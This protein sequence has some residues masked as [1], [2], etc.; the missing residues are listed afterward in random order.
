MARF[1]FKIVTLF[2]ILILTS[3]SQKP[4]AGG[5]CIVP[6]HVRSGDVIL[7]REGG[8]TSQIFATIA[9]E[10]KIFSHVGIIYIDHGDTTVLH[11]EAIETGETNSLRNESFCM[12]LNEA[13]TFSIYQLN[14]SDSLSSK[15]AEQAHAMYIAGAK[16]DYSFDAGTDS[17]LYCTEYVAKAINRATSDSTITPNLTIHGKKGFSIDDIAAFCKAQQ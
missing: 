8:M 17:L 14:V 5:D 3:C 9:S 10:E 16:F 1:I 12:F 4:D 15:V 11:C 13:D 7:R 6:S 2:T